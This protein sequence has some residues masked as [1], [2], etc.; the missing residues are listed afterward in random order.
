VY[1]EDGEPVLRFKKNI[2][3]T[4]CPCDIAFVEWITRRN[5]K[6]TIKVW[7]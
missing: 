6:V 5:S 1:K 7:N 2:L 4:I 3:Y